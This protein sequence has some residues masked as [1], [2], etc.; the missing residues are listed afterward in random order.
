MLLEREKNDFWFFLENDDTS[1]V[2]Q[3]L[4]NNGT[5]WLSQDLRDHILKKTEQYLT[6]KQ[7]REIL[8]K[9]NTYSQWY[10]CTYSN[11]HNQFESMKRGDEQEDIYE[12][13]KCCKNLV[14]FSKMSA[15]KRSYGEETLDNLDFNDFEEVQSR[16][17]KWQKLEKRKIRSIGY[18]ARDLKKEHLPGKKLW[19]FCQD[20]WL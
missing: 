15:L 5:N 13:L 3:L 2:N 18:S 1:T 19:N 4:A 8:S 9:N 12:N 17:L 7:E 6:L 10:H 16:L 11:N 14:K 20:N